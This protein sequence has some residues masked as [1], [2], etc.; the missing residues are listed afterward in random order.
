MVLDIV[1]HAVLTVQ[2]LLIRTQTAI[3]AVLSWLAQQKIRWKKEKKFVLSMSQELQ[4]V[5]LLESP[6]DAKIALL[7]LTIQDRISSV[8][9]S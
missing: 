9:D 1:L 2:I 5:K 3:A 6:L 8:V 7:V 4:M